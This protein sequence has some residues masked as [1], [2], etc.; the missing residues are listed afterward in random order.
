MAAAASRICWSRMSKAERSTTCSSAAAA[1]PRI[2]VTMVLNM[3][4]LLV[5]NGVHLG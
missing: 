4:D 1:A 3:G 5:M 2:S